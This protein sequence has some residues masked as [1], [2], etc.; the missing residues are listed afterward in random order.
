[1]QRLRF[2]PLPSLLYLEWFLLALALLRPLIAPLDTMAI[3]ALRDG[4][5]SVELGLGGMAG[6]IGW[7][8]LLTAVTILVVSW[9][10]KKI[11]KSLIGFTALSPIALISIG[12]HS[13]GFGLGWKVGAIGWLILLT[14][15]AI[16]VI[17]WRGKKVISWRGKKIDKSLIGLAALSSIILISIGGSFPNYSAGLLQPI[18]GITS[19]YFAWLGTQIERQRFGL[20]KWLY[21]L[22]V[23]LLIWYIF[24]LISDTNSFGKS[25]LESLF[26]LH[27][28]ALIRACLVFEGRK[29]WLIIGLFIASYQSVTL[30]I[31]RFWTEILG[32]FDR[33]IT[34]QITDI[35]QILKQSVYN[36]T[37]VF[38][39]I[40]VLLV[41]LIN[42]LISERRNREQLAQAHRQLHDY[43]QQIED[44]TML[45]E[46]NRIAREI[47]DAVGHT[48]TAQSIQLENA[49]ADFKPE[50]DRAYKFL[51]QAQTLS[52]SALQEVRRSVSQL[53]TDMLADQNFEAAIADLV[54]DFQQTCACSYH[55]ALNS[56]TMP[57]E[58]QVT[59]YRIIQEALTNITRHSGADAVTI[60]IACE[61][62]ISTTERGFCL[63][64]ADNGCGFKL[65]QITRGFG[66]QG[67]RERATAIG[68][69]WS[70]QSSPGQGCR[71][72]VLVP[73]PL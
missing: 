38:T 15:V 10:G 46:R 39:L 32:M 56:E 16:S 34:L 18:L 5:H 37:I 29:R 28:I 27:L 72:Q 47:H 17:S 58:V 61:P 21:I 24:F 1:M 53:R 20:N 48:L 69:E 50:P 33:P 65:E 8:I 35:E 13:D 2:H 22:I 49:I 63:Q 23:W 4:Q 31:G 66:L 71:I 12:G 62:G 43:A 25:N 42:T 45:A 3:I 41:L 70:I 40:T 14:A 67:M 30:V 59:F 54:T 51:T 73:M 36:V 55:H 7:L 26:L 60:E 6:A 9:R 52:H 57:I 44:Q 11:D 64:I 19:I 68:G